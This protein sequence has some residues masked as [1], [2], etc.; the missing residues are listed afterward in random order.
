MRNC[1]EK[2]KT[3]PVRDNPALKHAWAYWIRRIF[4]HWSCRCCRFFPNLKSPGGDCLAKMKY[5]VEINFGIKITLKIDQNNKKQEKHTLNVPVT[6]TA[7]AFGFCTACSGFL[8]S[9]RL[10]AFSWCS[11]DLSWFFDCCSESRLTFSW[12]TEHKCRCQA[13]R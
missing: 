7:S 3:L 6:L 4:L 2:E 9:L 5:S 10:T 13:Q 8:S 12:S 1:W 11:A